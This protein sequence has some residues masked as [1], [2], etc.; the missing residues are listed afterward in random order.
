MFN[1]SFT[2]TMTR[3]YKLH[4]IKNTR[5]YHTAGGDTDH[6]LVV[7]KVRSNQEWFALP[8][9]SAN[10]ISKLH[11]LDK[12][13]RKTNILI[14][15]LINTVSARQDRWMHLRTAFHESTLMHLERKNAK[16]SLPVMEPTVFAKRKAL[17]R[18]KDNLAQNNVNALRTNRNKYREIAKNARTNTGSNCA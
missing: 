15:N 3:R 11:A 13:K 5:S 1:I 14:L 9:Q 17:W 16:M 6:F 4:L 12:M 7:S 2:P 8:N 18:L 10:Q